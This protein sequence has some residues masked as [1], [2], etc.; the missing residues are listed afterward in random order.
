MKISPIGYIICNWESE[1][2]ICGFNLWF[3][4]L[5]SEIPFPKGLY[6]LQYHSISALRGRIDKILKVG[7]GDTWTLIRALQ[8]N[9]KIY[10]SRG[11]WPTFHK[12][13]LEIEVSDCK[14][15]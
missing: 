7:N 1:I 9:I 3:C 15:Y 2:N 11:L 6:F 13:L 8:N 5:D 12:S 4:S 10:P 14:S